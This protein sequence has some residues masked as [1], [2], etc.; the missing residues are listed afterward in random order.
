VQKVEDILLER[1]EL[2]LEGLHDPALA[3]EL[4]ALHVVE[5][6]EDARRAGAGAAAQLGIERDAAEARGVPG[7]R[8]LRCSR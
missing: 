7:G 4:V 5:D 6:L 1:G 2:G 3:D 8:P